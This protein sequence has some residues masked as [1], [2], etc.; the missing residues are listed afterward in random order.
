MRSF[1]SGLWVGFVAGVVFMALWQQANQQSE[2]EEHLLGP[3][4]AQS[5]AHLKPS[6]SAPTNLA[7]KL[8]QQA[9]ALPEESF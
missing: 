5:L 3:H 8:A 7:D 1:S 6:S 9:S 4:V 2:R